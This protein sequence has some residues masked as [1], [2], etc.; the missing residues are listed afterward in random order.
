MGGESLKV[1]GRE[2][3]D[4]KVGAPPSP[5]RDEAAAVAGVEWGYRIA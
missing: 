4:R 2:A 5:P 3:D 1:D